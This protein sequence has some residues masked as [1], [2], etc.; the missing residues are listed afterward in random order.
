ME[1]SFE[2]VWREAPIGIAYVDADGS[3]KNA[4]PALCDFL[5]FAEPELKAKKWSQITHPEDVE[6]D[7]DL[8]RDV[9]AGAIPGYNLVKR[10]LT[11]RGRVVW[12]TIRVIGVWDEQKQFLGY[13][14]F[15]AECDPLE[16]VQRSPETRPHFKWAAVKEYWIQIV[17]FIGVISAI[18]AEILKKR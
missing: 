4:N 14:V 6:V 2:I 9:R 18:A 17:F 7:V 5:E 1:R 10:Y 11:K 12:A 3:F 8:A 15:V 16:A 13:V